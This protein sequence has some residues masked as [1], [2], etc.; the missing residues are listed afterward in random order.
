MQFF[1]LNIK[2]LFHS[3]I[4]KLT[5]FYVLIAMTISVSF[6]IGLYNISSRELDR[7]LGRQARVLRDIPVSG[8][9]NGVILPNFDDVRSQQMQESSDRLRN[10]LIYFNLLVLLLSSV[11]SYLF[12]RRMLH[13]IEEA[14]ESQR[15]FT[16]D[17]S[18]EL[19]TPLTAMKAEIEVNL[20]DKKLGLPDS[21]KLL[22]SNLEEIEKL[23]SL[24]NSLLKLARYEDEATPEFSEISLEDVIVEAYEKVESLATKKSIEFKNKLEDI[25]ILG[26]KQSLIELFVI[27]LDN[28]VKY[29]PE[30]S[31]IFITMKEDKK[32]VIVSIKDLGVGIR[33]TELP[34]IFD[35]FYR[36]DSSR[37]KEKA[38][39]YGL[40][41]SIAKRIVD[42]HDGTIVVAS[43]PGKGS[44]FTVKLVNI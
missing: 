39:G 43:K 21:K 35:R 10:N 19:R 4:L 25:S 20:R 33:A 5:L 7:G 13:P 8:F 9:Q 16:A 2:N 26:D 15:R 40:G 29:S 24:S 22:Q 17:A 6:S 42:I 1:N 11:L 34:H 12:A 23:E 3:A 41:L 32:S 27:L 18:H 31:K 30:K 28:A 44:E 38:D 37:C 14:M 36:C